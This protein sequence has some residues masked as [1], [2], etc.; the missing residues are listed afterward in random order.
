MTNYA[1]STVDLL[2]PST[3][4]SLEQ[5]LCA[6]STESNENMPNESYSHSAPYIPTILENLPTGPVLA[7]KQEYSDDDYSEDSDAS[8]SWTS[9]P[10][11]QG[12]VSDADSSTSSHFTS[13]ANN[14][15]SGQKSRRSGSRRRVNDSYVSIS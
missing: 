10:A 13:H 6:Y 4:V 5:A 15:N 1:G 14:A 11:K 7:I 3:L 9:T 8:S 2:T 12:R